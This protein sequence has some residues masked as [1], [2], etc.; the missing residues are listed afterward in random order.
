MSNTSK[1]N[2]LNIEYKEQRQ[3]RSL[4][5]LLCHISRLE[6]DFKISQSLRYDSRISLD[7]TG[8]DNKIP[9]RK[10]R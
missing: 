1:C 10:T 9:V 2:L 3:V 8:F 6:T 7:R 5:L 4:S